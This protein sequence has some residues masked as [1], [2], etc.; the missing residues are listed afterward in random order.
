MEKGNQQGKKQNSPR[1]KPKLISQPD[2]SPVLGGPRATG[3][4]RGTAGSQAG[5]KD[6]AIRPGLGHCQDSHA[7]LEPASACLVLAETRGQRVVWYGTPWPKSGAWGD[8]SL[9]SLQ[10]SVDVLWVCLSFP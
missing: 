9:L 3:R 8:P 6:A 10:P 4:G 1:R 5:R 7:G 2:V